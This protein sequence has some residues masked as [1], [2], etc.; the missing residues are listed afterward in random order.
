MLYRCLGVLDPG[1][2]QLSVVVENQQCF[3]LNGGGAMAAAA[4]L[5]LSAQDLCYPFDGAQWL[6]QPDSTD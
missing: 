3:A 5:D 6:P 4:E 1:E 2:E